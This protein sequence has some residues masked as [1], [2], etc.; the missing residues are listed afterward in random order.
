MEKP[1]CERPEQSKCKIEI[2]C[3]KITSKKKVKCCPKFP[4][5][6]PSTTCPKPDP[7]KKVDP[8]PK[9]DPCLK[10]EPCP[11][12]QTDQTKKADLCPK[13]EPCVKSDP[14]KKPDP[15]CKSDSVKKADSCPK[16]EPCPRSDSCAKPDP[17]KKTDASSKES[18]CKKE[19]ASKSKQPNDNKNSRETSPCKKD[20]APK[21]TV[22]SKNISTDSFTSCPKPDPCKVVDQ[23]LKIEKKSNLCPKPEPCKKPDPCKVIDPRSNPC[24]KPDP[25]K[26]AVPCSKPDPCKVMDPCIKSNPCSKTDPCKKT[27]V[28]TKEYPCKT[29]CKEQCG[30]KSKQ[31]SDNKNPCISKESSTSTAKPF[32]EEKDIEDEGFT[33]IYQNDFK[34]HGSPCNKSNRNT[35]CTEEK[36]K[37]SIRNEIERKSNSRA[38]LSLESELPCEDD[39]C[40]LCTTP[41]K[42]KKPKD[43]PCDPCK[44]K[45]NEQC[46]PKPNPCDPCKPKQPQPCDP[47][48]PKPKP[49]DPCSKPKPKDC[50][51]C[52]P[53]PKSKCDDNPCEK[54][55]YPQV[56]PDPNL[57]KTPFKCPNKKNK[58]PCKTKSSGCN[59]KKNDPSTTT[60]PKRKYSQLSVLT[61]QRSSESVSESIMLAFKP[62]L[63]NNPNTSDLNL[64]KIRPGYPMSVCNLIGGNLII[65]ATKKDPGTKAEHKDPRT[66]IEQK[67]PFENRINKTDPATNIVIKEDYSIKTVT[68]IARG[69]KK[70]NTG[71]C[72]EQPCSPTSNTKQPCAKEEKLKFKQKEICKKMSEK[73]IVS[74]KESKCKEKVKRPPRKSGLKVCPE[75]KAI[76]SAKEE[77]KA[78][79]PKCI[80]NKKGL[81]FEAKKDWCYRF[82]EQAF[83]NDTVPVNPGA[84]ASCNK[85]KVWEDK[86]ELVNRRIKCVAKKCSKRK[87]PPTKPPNC[88]KPLPKRPHPCSQC[89]IPK[90]SSFSDYGPKAAEPILSSDQKCP[91]KPCRKKPCCVQTPCGEKKKKRLCKVR[92]RV[93]VKYKIDPYVKAK[94]MKSK[95]KKK[96]GQKVCPI[97]SRKIDHSL[98]TEWR[99]VPLITDKKGKLRKLT[100]VDQS[101]TKQLTDAEGPKNFLN[102]T[103]GLARS[104]CRV[105]CPSK[106]GNHGKGAASNLKNYKRN[107]RQLSC[108]QETLLPGDNDQFNKNDL[109]EGWMFLPRMTDL[110]EKEGNVDEFHK[111]ARYK[112]TYKCNKIPWKTK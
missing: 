18:S 10:T 110:L 103:K 95:P 91:K 74:S 58:D 97:P 34:P 13:P 28:S 60:T 37:L 64:L 59:T 40:K 43:N 52:K 21:A 94:R 63:Y 41:I 77:Q 47:C 38:L 8:C 42:C 1:P 19:C 7:C 45:D 68:L 54:V 96:K 15:C 51:P 30:S 69:K 36:K 107:T 20:C 2:K 14:C 75:R 53:K 80:C 12:P 46:K 24:P 5:R 27:N 105:F 93:V 90:K 29:L 73:R 78:C 44:S 112:I 9:P 33:T 99:A 108:L 49:C 16:P 86:K 65:P 23:C 4:F 101:A 81:D 22:P 17:C 61:K 35:C 79:G 3:K 67:D 11:K 50:D 55:D 71:G 56:K 31:S 85:F 6:C 92:R 98:H 82:C 62:G 83:I 48:K 70:M 76:P 25:C 39:R 32:C 104:I 84:C 111:I 87:F 88:C 72:T 109:S 106:G 66:E 102:G 100:S 26:K 89:R 57:K